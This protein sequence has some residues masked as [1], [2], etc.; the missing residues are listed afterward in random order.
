MMLQMFEVL[1]E[2]VGLRCISREQ[3]EYLGGQYNMFIGDQ[4]V[5]GARAFTGDWV[6][7]HVA[8]ELLVLSMIY[9]QFTFHKDEATGNWLLLT[10]TLPHQGRF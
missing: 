6:D 9:P 7:R 1:G 2:T 5:A 3:Y 8:I 4:Y 10:H